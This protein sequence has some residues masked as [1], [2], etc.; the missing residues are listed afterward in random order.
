MIENKTHSKVEIAAFQQKKSGTNQCGDDYVTIETEACF[1]CA[2]ADGL[3]SGEGAYHSASI[4][5]NTVRQHYDQDMDV[6][7]DKCN[8]ALLHERGV[9]LTIL[10]VVFDTNEIIY[11]NIGNIETYLF[12]EEGD[13]KRPIPAPG[14]LSGRKF[15]YRK[16]SYSMSQ[17]THFVMHSDGIKFTRSDQQSVQHMGCPRTAIKHFAEKA[18][19]QNDDITVIIGYIT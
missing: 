4:A 16:L 11:G 3:G 8:R 12:S 19:R 15:K 6:I 13:M 5:M 10:K 17:G 2:L 18:Q 7:L 14:Y 9:V 1:L